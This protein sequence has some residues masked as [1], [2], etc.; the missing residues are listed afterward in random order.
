[1]KRIEIS[2]E[3][4]DRLKS[5]VVDPFDDTPESVINRLVEIVE[6]AKSAWN[7]WETPEEDA[8]EEAKMEGAGVSNEKSWD[9]KVEGPL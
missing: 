9:K 6:K 7:S 8:P 5:C 4:Y 3:L 2:E 1:M